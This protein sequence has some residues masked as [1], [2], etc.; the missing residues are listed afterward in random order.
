M[1]SDIEKMAEKDLIDL[2]HRIVARL[3][4]LDQVRNHEKMIKFRIG[5][6]VMF[7]PDGYPQIAGMITKYN[8]KTDT[9]ITDKGEQ[10]NV[11]PGLLSKVTSGKNTDKGD[12]NILPFQMNMNKR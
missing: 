5:E 3:K 10:W 8:K 6:Q 7:Q 12:E 4:Y 2:N 1:K 9:L 11:A